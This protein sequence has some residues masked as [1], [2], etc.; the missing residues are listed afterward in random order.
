MRT[1]QKATLLACLFGASVAAAQTPPPRKP[2]L[3]RI[4]HIV[5]LFLENS[6]FDHLYGTFP[7]ADGVEQA[8]FLRDPGDAGR[9]GPIS[10]TSLRVI[11]TPGGLPSAIDSRFRSRD[12][13]RSVFA[14]IDTRRPERRVTGDPV[15]RFYQEQEQIDDGRDGQGCYVLQTLGVSPMGYFDASS[16]GL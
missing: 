1:F 14:R 13:K 9:T 12:P 8:G 7:G 2:G 6:S 3:D 10:S 15:H 5:V 11:Y 4:G 16:L